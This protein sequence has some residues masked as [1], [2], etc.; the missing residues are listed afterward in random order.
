MSTMLGSGI[1]SVSKQNKR[2]LKTPFKVTADINID[3]KLQI[4]VI[5][6]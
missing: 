2:V 4:L 5:N 1:K 3:V 6:F